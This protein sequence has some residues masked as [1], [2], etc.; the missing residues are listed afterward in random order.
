MGGGDHQ[1][2]DAHHQRGA[3]ERDEDRVEGDREDFPEIGNHIA[4]CREAQED[5]DRNQE[6]DRHRHHADDEAAGRRHPPGAERRQ[7]D[8]ARAGIDVA[9][10]VPGMEFQHQHRDHEQEGQRGDLRRRGQAV[11]AEPDIDDSEGQRLQGEILDR[12]EIRRRLHQD[13]RQPGGDRRPGQRQAHLAEQASVVDPRELEQGMGRQLE[14]RARHHVDIRVEHGAHHQDG[15]AH[16]ADFGKPV[17]AT[18]PPAEG[19]AQ[20]ALHRA[21]IVEEIRVDIG[22]EVGRH[23]EGQDEHPF[24]DAA[25]EEIVARHHP[26]RAHAE[27]E[28]DPADSRHEEK[29]VG[30]VA[31]QHRLEE[32]PP[33]PS[34]VAGSGSENGKDRRQQ[35]QRQGQRGDRPAAR[36]REGK[37]E[38]PAR[39]RRDSYHPVRSI[40]L[41]AAGESS[42]MRA[43]GSES[44]LKSPQERTSE[45]AATAG[46][47]G[48]S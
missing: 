24:E 17:I 48:Y 47:T 11:H 22:D 40:T 41:C 27:H 16:G 32:V 9:A 20:R 23:G 3:G 10:A 25:T 35:G 46:F 36:P 42:A 12:A 8:H 38:A 18:R 29:R 5:A 30:D 7:A 44:P 6:P 37:V 13:E 15:A 45:E 14:G 31:G 1:D 43:I 34:A 26:R 28:A 4:P 33:E 2:R 19:V 39:R 21:G